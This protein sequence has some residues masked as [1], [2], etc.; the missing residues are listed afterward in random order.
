M[1]RVKRI[2]GSSRYMET[3]EYNYYCV[4]HLMDKMLFRIYL[5]CEL[6]KL[7]FN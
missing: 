1:I 2:S 5:T 6:L 7:T 4:T 3:F